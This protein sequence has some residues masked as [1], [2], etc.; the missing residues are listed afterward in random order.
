[1]LDVIS[2]VTYLPGSLR[3]V[4]LLFLLNLLK[5]IAPVANILGS[6]RL[7]Q[8]SDKVRATHPVGSWRA[9]GQW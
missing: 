1:M 4:S 2:C 5:V 9:G 6:T 3:I 8:K 7:L